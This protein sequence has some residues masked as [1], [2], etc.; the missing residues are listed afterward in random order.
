LARDAIHA[1]FIPAGI[2]N[3]PLPSDRYASAFWMTQRFVDLVQSRKRHPQR[4]IA[5]H[6]NFGTRNDDAVRNITS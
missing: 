4:A 1:F 2:T 5:R 6:L 3:T